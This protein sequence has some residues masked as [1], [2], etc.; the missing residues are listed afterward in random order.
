MGYPAFFKPKESLEAFD[1]NVWLG[2]AVKK[3][4]EEA[5]LI[6]PKLRTKNGESYRYFDADESDLLE[7]LSRP[8]PIAK[9]R[10]KLTGLQLRYV[11]GLHLCL[12]GEAFWLLD[13]RKKVNGVPTRIDLLMPGNVYVKHDPVTGDL[14]E[15]VYRLYER[16]ITLDPLDVVHFKFPDPKNW[17]RGHAPTQQI[18]YAVDTYREAELMNLKRLEN[19]AVPG[20]FLKTQDLKLDDAQRKRLRAEW[21]QLH[22]GTDN[23]GRM[24][25]LTKGME[26]DANQMTNTEMQYIEGKEWNRDEILANYGISLEVL[27]QTDSVTRANAE[28]AIF[29][30]MRFGALFFI[31]SIFDVMNNDLKPAFVGNDKNE[32]CFDD[33]VPE[34]VED[35]RATAGLLYASGAMTPDGMLK[36]FGM[37]PLKIKGVTDIP[38]IPFSSVP[39]GQ[40]PTSP[41]T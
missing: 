11:T 15:Y 35:K 40:P 30:F 31:K 17:S 27:G 29:V 10:S 8:Q 4:A 32:L 25:I 13:G 1:Y 7:L 38:Y 5:A 20:G 22:R 2:R 3:L 6:E 28:A 26:F 14:L 12:N 16:E 37:E 19:N 41:L 18:R 34:N 39:A 33:P 9:G 21:E 36:Y 23:A 24:A